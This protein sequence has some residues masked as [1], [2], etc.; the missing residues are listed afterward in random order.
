MDSCAVISFSLITMSKHGPTGSQLCTF[1][2]PCNADWHFLLLFSFLSTFSPVSLPSL[3]SFCRLCLFWELI[4]QPTADQED[5]GVEQ[6][7][8]MHACLRLTI[9][10]S[11]DLWGVHQISDKPIQS[12]SIGVVCIYWLY[13]W[14]FITSLFNCVSVQN[15]WNVVEM[16]TSLLA[17]YISDCLK[18]LYT[19]DYSFKKNFNSNSK[20]N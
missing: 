4:Q 9:E 10:C 1:G 8:L 13:M 12:H 17:S 2:W 11:R 16:F 7:E 18:W 6:G 5:R 20:S 14:G 15:T 19:I 3:L